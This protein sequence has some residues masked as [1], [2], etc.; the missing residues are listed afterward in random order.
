MLMYSAR[1][2]IGCRLKNDLGFSE[3]LKKSNSFELIK[4]ANETALFDNLIL[5]VNIMS[6][7]IE[8]SSQTQRKYLLNYLSILICTNQFVHRNCRK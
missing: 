5:V 1:N 8:F 2:L 7:N 6:F 3:S 4:I